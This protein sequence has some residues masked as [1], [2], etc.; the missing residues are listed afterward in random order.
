M[1][2]TIKVL[3]VNFDGGYDKDHY[4]RAKEYPKKTKQFQPAKYG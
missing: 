4:N 2:A 3:D 1:F